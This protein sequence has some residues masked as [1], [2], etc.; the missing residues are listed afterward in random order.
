MSRRLDREHERQPVLD[1]VSHHALRVGEGHPVREV[2]GE[3]QVD[4]VVDGDDG[5]APAEERE[6]VVG[7]VKEVDAQA[8]Q[9]E[10]DR[11]VLLEPVTA[12]AVHHG[13]EVL[14]QVAQGGLVRRIAEQEVGRLPVEV[15]EMAHQVSDVRPDPVVTP[16]AHVDGDLGH[17]RCCRSYLVRGG[18]H[19][20]S[21]MGIREPPLKPPSQRAAAA[22]RR[23]ALR[24]VRACP[25]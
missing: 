1:R 7:R 11:D 10:R 13:H 9:L 4:A 6:D 2:L 17:G 15:R 3:K 20:A 21:A 8:P 12:R 14:G 5:A 25:P 18:T 22:Q 16:L 23:P 19:A 24:S